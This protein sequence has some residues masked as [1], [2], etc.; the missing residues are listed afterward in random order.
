MDYEVYDEGSDCNMSDIDDET[1]DE[2]GRQIKA[3]EQQ[4][5][6]NDPYLD[7]TDLAELGPE[8]EIDDGELEE[9]AST[10][11]P[12]PLGHVAIVMVKGLVKAIKH[13]PRTW[14]FTYRV[15]ASLVLFV[16]V[17]WFL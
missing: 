17:S 11:A 8:G 9:E 14:Q 6:S 1:L 15:G 5:S 3:D 2:F 4:A 13:F 12:F 7:V 10:N 16:Y